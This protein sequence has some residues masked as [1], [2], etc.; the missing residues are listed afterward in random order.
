[1]RYT[2]FISYSHA[3][4]GRLAP[5]LQQALHGF[6]KPWYRRRSINVF[7]DQ[8]SLAAS[9]ALWPS[10]EA[11][12]R[13][14]AWFLFMASPQAARSVWVQKEI[15]WWLEHRSAAR[16][17]VL[18]TD[19]T[20]NWDSQAGDFDWR[21]TTA[22]P[23]QLRKRFADEPLYVDLR[24]ARSEE[25]LSVRH[26]Q[27]RG[28]LLDIAAPLHG[29]PKE[30][31]DGEDVRQQRR[32]KAWAW[33]AGAALSVLAVAATAAAIY[34]VSQRNEALHQRDLATARQREAEARLAFD[35]SGE[36]LVK[37]TLLAVDSL[38][39]AQ[40]TEGMDTMG[41]FLRLLPRKPLWRQAP[42]RSDTSGQ[43]RPSLAFSPDGRL[44]ASTLAGEEVTWLDAITGRETRRTATACHPSNRTTLAFSPNGAQLAVGCAHQVCVLDT[45][46][47]GPCRLLPQNARHG[48]M[49][50]AAAFSPD[51]K[52][53]AT[54]SYHSDEVFAYDAAAWTA[55]P[56]RARQGPAVRA[57]AISPDSQWL[58]TASTDG[59]RLWKLGRYDA[60]VDQVRTNS[61]AHTVAFD[62]ASDAFVT[63]GQELVRW[64][65]V[66]SDDG[67]TRLQQ[68]AR[69]TFNAHTLLPVTWHGQTCFVAAAST[70]VSLLCGADFTEVLRV[71]VS[72]TAATLSPDGKRL[73]NRET[74]GSLAAW[75]LDGDTDVRR[76]PLGAATSAM[77]LASDDSWLAIAMQDGSIVVLDTQT[78][79][80]RETLHLPDAVAGLVL[81]ADGRRLAANTQTTLSVFDTETWKSLHTRNYAGTQGAMGFVAQD[82]LLIAAVGRS[83]IGLDT[84]DWSRRFAIAH[85]GAL[86][87]IAIGPGAARLQLVTAYGGGHDTGVHLTRV[88]DL[89]SARL[90]AWKYTSGGGSFSNLRME[91]LIA[92]HR[93]TATGGDAKLVADST[94]WQ[95]I[96]TKRPEDLRVP[97]DAPRWRITGGD[98]GVVRLWPLLAKDLAAEA[99]ARLQDS[100]TSPPCTSP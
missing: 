67:A 33:S 61:D 47:D 85:D 69:S 95:A 75:P 89:A 98:D 64:R 36:G 18:L 99:C 13:E 87:R 58:V 30:D 62:P 48:D 94:T 3:A 7:R 41:R 24:W 84:A 50:W 37:A 88:I 28:A 96:S 53:L 81:S 20:M 66:A 77:I 38:R 90:L 4:D 29:K 56:D 16:M 8:T 97:R 9:P 83:V 23:E 100:F 22:L 15:L 60:V 54:A 35:Q 2:A 27:F 93:S 34:A 10:I 57:V 91:Q 59:V 21:T 49:V 46:G 82:R 73:I 14:S 78:W 63:G 44:I 70:A 79:K 40:T 42:V 72:S 1:M 86:E 71:P 52:V 80:P 32:N 65:I 5:R 31:L 55:K 11:A 39:S 45:H 51:A 76:I 6:A 68:Q 92:S 26:L 43:P 74:D 19:G 17:L 25:N 12:L